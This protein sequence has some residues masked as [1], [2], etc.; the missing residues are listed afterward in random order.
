MSKPVLARFLHQKE[1]NRVV[2]AVSTGRFS[3]RDGDAAFMPH[4]LVSQ[5]E[6][7]LRVSPVRMGDNPDTFVQANGVEL[8]ESGR[9]NPG[10]NDPG[11]AAAAQ[12]CKSGSKRIKMAFLPMRAMQIKEN[13]R[14]AKNHEEKST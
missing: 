7:G 5:G 2:E 13:E 8:L 10:G 3:K 12:R 4:V 14:E 9:E 6:G 1:Q 11:T